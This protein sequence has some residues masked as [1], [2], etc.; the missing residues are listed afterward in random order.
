MFMPKNPAVIFMNNCHRT[1]GWV[2]RIF[3]IIHKQGLTFFMRYRMTVSWYYVRVTSHFLT[4]IHL[5]F[6]CLHQTQFVL[7]MWLLYECDRLSMV[8]EN[9]I[10][11]SHLFF[12]IL[13]LQSGPHPASLL[14]LQQISELV[15]PQSRFNQSSGR[16]LGGGKTRGVWYWV[17]RSWVWY[18]SGAYG[19]VEWSNS[20]EGKHYTFG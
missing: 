9:V 10:I 13:F 4:W 12:P 11:L 14:A 18:W 7:C 8:E 3:W 1:C 17:G 15:L 20:K 19:Q 5:W 16:S 2:T 6:G